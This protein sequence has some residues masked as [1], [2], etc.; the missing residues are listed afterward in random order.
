[1][2]ETAVQRCG[3]ASWSAATGRRRPLPPL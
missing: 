2:R 3:G 1:V